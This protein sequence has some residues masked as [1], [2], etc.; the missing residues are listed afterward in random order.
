MIYYPDTKATSSHIKHQA[1]GPTIAY[2]EF[3][4]RR[5]SAGQYQGTI[6]LPVWRINLD[7]INVIAFM[8]DEGII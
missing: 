3:I 8:L 4:I 5:G 6:L 2:Q 1:D 7:L